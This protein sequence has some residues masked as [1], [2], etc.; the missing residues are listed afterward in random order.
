MSNKQLQEFVKGEYFLG[1]FLVR[2]QKELQENIPCATFT[3]AEISTLIHEYVHFLQDISTQTGLIYFRFYAELLH[4]YVYLGQKNHKLELPIDL[5]NCGVENG[6]EQYELLA[7]YTGSEE[8]LKIHHIN[9]ILAEKEE[10]L[11]EIFSH[12]DSLKDKP[13][14][15]M[16]IYYDDNE[17]KRYYF[18]GCCVRESM[19]YLIER[20]AFDGEIREHEFPYN[21]CEMVCEKLCPE[22]LKRPELIVAI[23][24]L[25]LMHYHSGLEFC[26][27]VKHISEEKLKF[28]NVTEL[29]NYFYGKIDF[30]YTNYNNAI[31][32][33]DA[34]I[35]FLF[36]KDLQ[37][38][39]KVNE[40]VKSFFNRGYELRNQN[41][42]FIT[43]VL[44]CENFMDFVNKYIKKIAMPLLV[45]SKGA[46][47]S[48]A[49]L[50]YIPVPM[51]VLE[52]FAH[53]EYGCCLRRFGIKCDSCNF[54]EHV[55]FKK[56]WLQCK[57]KQE[58]CPFAAY[59]RHY[60]L[61]D[62]TFIIKD[63]MECSNLLKI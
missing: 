16:A 29:Y 63:R 28:K 7:L 4:L 47:Y 34:H 62:V 54:D 60:K 50:Q 20:L 46:M 11:E 53:P 8:H 13:I 17:D 36:S 19:A 45:D 25:S 57:H 51:A 40:S 14:Q 33:I 55:C 1:V 21:A 48:E 18:G 32:D 22:L 10:L 56:P 43:D 23:C 26:Y 27:L 44:L 6:F 2:F 12:N 59:L 52:F 37:Y 41:R 39:R 9:K 31:A 35:N 5:E 15:Q 24:E 58:L 3:K 30:L 49:D 38:M 61:D 42:L